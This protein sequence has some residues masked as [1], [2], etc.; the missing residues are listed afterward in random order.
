MEKGKDLGKFA[1]PF[2]NN[3]SI[4]CSV[5]GNYFF[6]SDLLLKYIWEELI[7]GVIRSKSRGI[8]WNRCV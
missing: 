8:I 5:V 2:S 6:S 1:V 4:Q 7:L 3:R